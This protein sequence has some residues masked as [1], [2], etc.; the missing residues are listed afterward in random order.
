MEEIN[1]ICKKLSEKQNLEYLSLIHHISPKQKDIIKEYL[2]KANP[3]LENIKLE[4]CIRN[5]LTKNEL[6]IINSLNM[7]FTYIYL[8]IYN[9]YK[10]DDNNKVF[11]LFL[12][13]LE[14]YLQKN[15]FYN[16]EIIKN[17]INKTSKENNVIEYCFNI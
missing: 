14:I 12:N 8:I 13:E 9:F 7:E 6:N 11:N 5:K 10:N 16:Y 15:N 1:I 17:S 3:I 4:D 2:D